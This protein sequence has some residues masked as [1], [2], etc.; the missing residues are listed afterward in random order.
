MSYIFIE[1]M[2]GKKDNNKIK[3]LIIN[4]WHDDVYA[5]STNNVIINL[6]L[7]ILL[8]IYFRCEKS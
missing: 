4:N 8:I 3:R 2:N 6:D 7:T 1:K 5:Y